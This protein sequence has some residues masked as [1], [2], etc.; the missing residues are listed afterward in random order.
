MF[1]HLSLGRRMLG[2]INLSRKCFNTLVAIER[3]YL[4][5]CQHVHVQISNWS[6]SVDALDK[7]VRLLPSLHPHFY[8]KLVKFMCL[9]ASM[10]HFVFFFQLMCL[11][12]KVIT[13]VKQRLLASVH[14]YVNLQC[15]RESGS[16]IV[17]F[18]AVWLFSY[19]L[20]HL[21]LS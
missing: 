9:F 8:L 19:M 10:C 5:V 2:M 15:I 12:V 7:S 17:L 13:L 11:C 16:V 3:S 1:T 18:A 21:V 4:S 6:A 14:H 20:S